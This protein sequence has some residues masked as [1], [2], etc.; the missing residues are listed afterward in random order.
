MSRTVRRDCCV[1][2]KTRV[3]VVSPLPIQPTLNAAL[4]LTSAVL[5][6]AG[7]RA[8][9]RKA[10]ERHRRCMLGACVASTLFLTS[11]LIYHAQVGARHFAGTG[12]M[13]PL[14]FT[15][16]VSHTLLAM[17]IVPLVGRTL[18]LALRG[19]IERHRAIARW[20]L[21][22]WGYVSVTGVVIYG[23]LYWM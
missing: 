6:A 19:R 4:N 13:R 21:P 12:W 14:Y 17:V 7:Y 23:M 9:R 15:I 8:I 18:Y 2:E 5:L 22:L 16:L 10:V 1:P 3:V 11:Y 20:T